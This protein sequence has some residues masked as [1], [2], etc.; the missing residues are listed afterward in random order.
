MISLEK[1]PKIDAHFH[2]TS[3]DPIY[4]K[5][6]KDFNV[7]FLN[8]N[9]DANVFPSVAEQEAVACGYI[10]KHPQSFAFISSFEMDGWENEGWLYKTLRRISVARKRGAVGVKIWKNIGMEIVKSSDKSFLMIDDPFFDPLFH[11]LIENNIPVLTH[12]GEPKNCWLSLD[13]MTSNRNRIY[14]E[15]NPEYH[16]YLH[17]EIPNYESQIRARDNVLEKYEDLI[18]VGAHLGSL[19]W[20]YAELAKRFDKYP[21]FYVDVS[22]R[23]GHMQMQSAQNYDD[24]RDFFIKYADRILY[25]TDAYNNPQ[26]LTLALENDWKYLA[27]NSH[28]LSTDID[29]AFKGLDLPEETI[30][31]IY[32][33]NAT[34]VYR[35]LIF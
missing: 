29:T 33:E 27:T 10:D 30:Y 13:E 8:I 11:F 18:F 32:F 5:I 14:Y 21:N 28:C 34:R 16:A 1:F 7:R 23:L 3:Y 15:N 20:S 22:S 9:T 4:E 26:K 19:E 35:R 24:V 2:A 17:P 6:A 12:L 25:G 31:K